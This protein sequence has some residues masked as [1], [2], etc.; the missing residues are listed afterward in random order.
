MK[1][2]T[3]FRLIRITLAFTVA[4]WMA[5]AGCLLGCENNVAAA[6]TNSAHHTDSGAAVVSDDACAASRSASCCASH[7]KSVKR[8]APAKHG[9]KSSVSHGEL[10]SPGPKPLLVNTKTWAVASGSSSMM[11]C[12]L[13][14]NPT[15]ALSHS[16]QDDA[17]PGLALRATQSLTNGVE[18][19]TAL[20]RRPRLP[21]RGHTYLRCCVFLI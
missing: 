12:P 18:Q 10:S 13:A 1:L 21:N 16:G 4:F 17:A 11:D 6:S 7:G 9:V 8:G 19:V 15:A 3:S 14:A 2:L 5:G 20:A